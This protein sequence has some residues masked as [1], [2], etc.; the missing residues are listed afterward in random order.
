MNNPGISRRTALGRAG[1]VLGA[2]ALASTAGSVLLAGPA[3][4]APGPTVPDGKEIDAALKR[5]R[6]RRS[7]VFTGKPSRNGWEMEKA[8]DAGGSIWTRQVP[9]TQLDGVAVRL[10]D[11]ET[12]LLHVIRRFHYEIDAL[13]RGDVIGWR[14]PGEVR[15]G[16]AEGNQASGTAVQIR[17]GHYPHGAKGGFFP[18]QLVVVRDILAELDG[19]VRWGGDDAKPDESLFSIAVRPGDT[20]LSRVAAKLRGWSD[21]PSEGPGTQV[22]V[23]EKGR[24]G[25]ARALERR[26]RATAA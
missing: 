22:D 19:T 14:S 1:A 25:S 18:S 12:V 26:Q 16:L 9:G 3:Y 2:A 11:V 17:P 21:T 8:A 6:D 7:R 5:Y 4:A 24:R 20:R 15:K 10:G 13:R 23:L